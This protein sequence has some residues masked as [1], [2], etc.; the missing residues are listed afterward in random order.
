M[1]SERCE[2]LET[3]YNESQDATT[4]LQSTTEE[5][6]EKIGLQE[7]DIITLQI[8][9]GDAGRKVMQRTPDSQGS[10]PSASS[11]K[12]ASGTS[13]STEWNMVTTPREKTKQAGDRGSTPPRMP[14]TSRTKLYE[15]TDDA[16]NGN[17]DVISAMKTLLVD[18]FDE[19]SKAMNAQ[20]MEVTQEIQAVAQES[21]DSHM[22]LVEEFGQRFAR[23]ETEWW[24]EQNEGTFYSNAVKDTPNAAG[25]AQAAE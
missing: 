15:K 16:N 17:V 6:N 20:R 11:A 8:S 7:Q 1:C 19:Q 5:Q 10:E 25:Y 18:K 22:Q 14:N 3:D 21:R 24:G 13:G 4:Y 9:I 12:P 23:L 2:E